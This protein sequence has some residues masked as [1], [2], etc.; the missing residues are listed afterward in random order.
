MPPTKIFSVVKIFL[1]Y[2]QESFS[3]FFRY[4]KILLATTIILMQQKFRLEP[5]LLKGVVKEHVLL[6]R[7]QFL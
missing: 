3:F 6:A 2:E 1:K 5:T 7:K 4:E